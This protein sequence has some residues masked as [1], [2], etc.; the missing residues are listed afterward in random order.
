M[1]KNDEVPTKYLIKA[2][3]ESE[4]DYEEGRCSPTFD[5]AKDAIAWLHDDHAK[6]VNGECACGKKHA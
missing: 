3:K 5:N 4:K 1:K 6:Y 2:L